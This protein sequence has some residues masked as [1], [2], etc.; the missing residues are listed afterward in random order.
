MSNA[1]STSETGQPALQA[2]AH[3]PL[4]QP[5]A[6][7]QR[8]LAAN[9]PKG[10][11]FIVTIYGD[12]VEPRGGVLWMGNL[13]EACAAVGISESLVR[14]AVSRL[15]AA[16][17]LEG[18]R[19]GRR[20]FYRLT[21]EARAEFAYA[22]SILY[23]PHDASQWRLVYLGG[24]DPDAAMRRLKR[25]GYAA[26]NPRLA[27]GPDGAPELAADAL[28]WDASVVQGGAAMRQFATEYWD[29]QSYAEAFSA[30][31]ERFA[32]VQ[33]MAASVEPSMALTLRLLLVHQYRGIALRAP[34]LPA[35]ALPPDWAGHEARR[36]FAAL[37]LALSRPAERH[38]ANH[39]ID[40]DG[41][42]PEAGQTVRQRSAQLRQMQ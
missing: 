13:I 35:Q 34:R 33:A 14:T 16:G 2:G 28:V 26:L 18:E 24:G 29:F 3:A 17:Q 40:G 8:L 1:N 38:I 20:S 10:A 42:L 27:I 12:V 9:P 15:V 31:I 21:A 23:E 36:L 5:E 4:G 6:V 25:L 30:F 11:A 22:A 37:Y 32:P 39:F 7:V 41:A 19:V